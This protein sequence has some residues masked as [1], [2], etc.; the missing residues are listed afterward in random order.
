MR[1]DTPRRRQ[2]A[3]R[4]AGCTS[5]PVPI[6]MVLRRLVGRLRRRAMRPRRVD[7]A[8]ETEQRD[9]SGRG[10]QH[11]ANSLGVGR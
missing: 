1:T 7:E 2:G 8:A 10:E 11:Q 6:G 9:G 5:G 3:L 4:L